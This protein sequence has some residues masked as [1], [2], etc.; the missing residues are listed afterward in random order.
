MLFSLRFYI[1]QED[2]YCL[3]HL[4]IKETWALNKKDLGLNLNYSI[5]H[6]NLH[7]LQNYSEPIFSTAEMELIIS[8]HLISDHL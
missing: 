3:K 4:K 2:L 7:N 5:I 1:R 6:M 8:N